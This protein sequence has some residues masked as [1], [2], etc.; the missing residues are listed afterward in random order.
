MFA[1][2]SDMATWILQEIGPPGE[3]A[4]VDRADNDG[5]YAPGNLRWASRTEQGGNK[6]RYECWKYGA[7][8]ST[9]ADA[10][11]DLS[12]ETI[13]TWIVKGMTDDEIITRK[14]SPGGRPR[15]RHP[16]LR[17]TK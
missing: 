7:R 5:D 3:G 6:R 2:A 11:P 14:K 13:R 15:V 10:R 16:R 4:T 17:A 1:S 8:I 12:Y 9:L